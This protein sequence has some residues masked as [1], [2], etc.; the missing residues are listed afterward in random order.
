[1]PIT[2]TELSTK[3]VHI[4]DLE[5]QIDKKGWEKYNSTRSPNPDLSMRLRVGLGLFLGFLSI[6][7]KNVKEQ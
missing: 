2:P 4:L 3:I 5:E 7:C 1:M 6:K